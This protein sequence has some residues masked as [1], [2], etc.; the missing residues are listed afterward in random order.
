MRLPVF[1]QCCPNN[2]GSCMIFTTKHVFVTHFISFHESICSSSS[3]RVRGEEYSCDVQYQSIKYHVSCTDG[4]ISVRIIYFYCLF[5]HRRPNHR[6]CFLCCR[7]FVVNTTF[8]TGLV[9]ALTTK[10]L[11]E[12]K[13][14]VSGTTVEKR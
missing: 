11:Q 10:G 6:L 1:S 14:L 3:L 12:R 4:K 2:N 8:S 9:V 5:F 7:P 13:Q